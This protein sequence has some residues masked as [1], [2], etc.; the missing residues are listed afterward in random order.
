MRAW[1]GMRDALV[2]LHRWVGLAMALF[3]LVEGLTGSILAFE[4]PLA[5][6]LTPDLGAPAAEAG[7]PVLD[8]ASLAT[9]AERLAP[10]AQVAYFS[11][12]TP[13]QV[14]ARCVPR[15]DPAS[16]R[17]YALAFTHIVLDPHDGREIGRY[18]DDQAG[19][20]PAGRILPFVKALHYNL[21]IGGPGAWVL[22]FV[23]LAWTLD[24]FVSALL[25]LPPRLGRFLS[26]WKPSWLLKWGASAYRVNVDL[27]R[28]G[29]LWFW[30]L[31]FVFA[32]SSVNLEDQ[33]GAYDAVTGAL[34]Y[35]VPPEQEIASWPS[36][37]NPDPRL[38][39]Y[40]AQRRG[41]DLMA[42]RARD[43]GFH[44]VAPVDLVHLIDNGMYNYSVRTDRP[45]P[46]PAIETVFFDADTGD[47]LP[48]IESVDRHTG[49]RV[50]NWLRA[51][52]MVI[53]PL[54]GLAYRIVVC[55]FG[56]VLTV[57]CVTGVIIWLRKRAARRAT[58]CHMPKHQ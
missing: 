19:A 35:Y 55:A 13:D 4:A 21:A 54:D 39:W 40:A 37:R 41:M 29:G 6:W 12:V 3:L 30:A 49:N 10:Q 27:H 1:F 51:L 50:T 16:G 22:L 53:D 14:V 31:L 52:H 48:M 9:A 17:P 58:F 46:A 15:I 2:W 7:Q 25:T 20:G 47:P 26:R 36:H 44:V 28:A 32:W 57:L 43:Q 24:C 45:F 5:R 42:Q 33:A 56:L 34:F 38:D 8:L 18:G 23:A 11:G